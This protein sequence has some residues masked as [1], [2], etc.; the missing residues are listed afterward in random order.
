ML[1]RSVKDALDAAKSYADTVKSE[2]YGGT[3]SETLDTITKISDAL[4]KDKDGSIIDSIYDVIGSKANA[5]HTHL[6]SDLA[7]G[8]YTL[9]DAASDVA[10]SDTIAAALAKIDRRAR[11]ASAGSDKWNTAR[12]ITFKGAVTGSV[13]IDGS[14]N[15][16]T[17]LDLSNFASN[18]VTAMT[19]YAVQIGRASCR[20]RV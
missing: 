1:F 4:N 12:T 2:I 9:P 6:G 19:N 14:K 15:V 13:S 3:P 5:N 18:K 7:I 10:V 17:T 20:E 16:E 8:T 11:T